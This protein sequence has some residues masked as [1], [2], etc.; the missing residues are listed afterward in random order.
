LTETTKDQKEKTKKLENMDPQISKKK[1]L[2]INPESNATH[3]IS[4]DF[5]PENDKIIVTLDNEYKI[6]IWQWDK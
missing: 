3:F 1:R 2:L 5:C 6:S 4:C